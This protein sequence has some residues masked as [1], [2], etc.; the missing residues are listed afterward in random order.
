M[1]VSAKAR[2]KQ[3]EA[4]CVPPALPLVIPD[5]LRLACSGGER[6]LPQVSITDSR[7]S[8]MESERLEAC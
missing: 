8:K 4:A 2:R 7:H 6:D 5:P 3:D 1:I